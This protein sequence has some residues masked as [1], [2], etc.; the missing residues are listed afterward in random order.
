VLNN[1][2]NDFKSHR[3]LTFLVQVAKGS[4]CRENS[5]STKA[6]YRQVRLSLGLVCVPGTMPSP[7]AHR[8]NGRIYRSSC[9]TTYGLRH[10]FAAGRRVEHC[11]SEWILLPRKLVVRSCRADAARPEHLVCPPGFC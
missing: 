7:R 5:K 3:A 8:T 11:Q 4:E 6:G 9:S 10:N 2:S 1:H